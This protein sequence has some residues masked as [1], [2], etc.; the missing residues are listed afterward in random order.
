MKTDINSFP[1]GPYKMYIFYL[2]SK[3]RLCHKLPNIYIYPK[4]SESQEKYSAHK[5]KVNPARLQ[6]K[7]NHRTLSGERPLYAISFL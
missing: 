5:D 6:I 3:L 4:H 1:L 7:L 2:N